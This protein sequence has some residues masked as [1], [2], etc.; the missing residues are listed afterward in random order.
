MTL[1]FKNRNDQIIGLFTN[2]A[3][4]MHVCEGAY[5][6]NPNVIVTINK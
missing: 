6:Y 5:Q 3:G 1:L 4:D 2:N